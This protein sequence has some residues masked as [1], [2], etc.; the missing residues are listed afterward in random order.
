MSARRNVGLV[1]VVGHLQSDAGIEVELIRPLSSRWAGQSRVNL[2]FQTAALAETL[3]PVGAM[4]ELVL[5]PVT[6]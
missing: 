5:E 1:E 6:R 3:F 2:R 4:F